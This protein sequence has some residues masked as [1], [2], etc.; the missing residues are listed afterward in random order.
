MSDATPATPPAQPPQ[1]AA[2]APRK[3]RGCLFWLTMVLILV[4]VI[5]VAI[6][7]SLWYGYYRVTHT[8]DAVAKPTPVAA[9][10]PAA[11]AAAE[12]SYGTNDA[13]LRAAGALQ[14]H[15]S[16]TELNDM[17]AVVPKLRELRERVYISGFD[18]NQITF[19]LSL[20]LDALGMPGR[21]FN[22]PVVIGLEG[23]DGQP[24]LRLV[25]VGEPGRGVPDFLL[26]RLTGD[27]LLS[28]VAQYHPRAQ[29]AVDEFRQRWQAWE[30][31]DG[32]LRLDLK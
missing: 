9:P 24:R 30:A 26:R 5:L 27:D 22:G 25:Q 2:P 10:A 1:A 4:V 20:P 6:A 28:S 23:A 18:K 31:R 17:I 8:L 32:V 16:V 19:Q 15:V 12:R 3:K 29:Q 11:A 7:G 13:Q 14:F 21:Y